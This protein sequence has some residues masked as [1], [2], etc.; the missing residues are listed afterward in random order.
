MEALPE[1]AE[2]LVEAERGQEVVFV[3]EGQELASWRAPYCG[4][5]RLTAPRFRATRARMEELAEA[6]S[7]RAPEGTTAVARE[8][9]EPDEAGEQEWTLHAPI[10]TSAY[11]GR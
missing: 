3:T 6:L 1:G 7:A 10:V 2:A 11:S 4:A 8:C 9:S 5:R